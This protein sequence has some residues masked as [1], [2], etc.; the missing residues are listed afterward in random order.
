MDKQPHICAQFLASGRYIVWFN[1]FIFVVA[2][3]MSE[4]AWCKVLHLLLALILL[5]LH[6]R[7]DFDRR[8]FADFAKNR[9]KPEE[10]D[11]VLDSWGWL[12]NRQSR[13]MQQR[14]AGALK[15]WRYLLWATGIQV[16][17]IAWK[18]V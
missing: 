9:F 12:R 7:L 8:I 15:L 17:L 1:A 16:G 11:A 4:G 14:V 13:E 6:I 3:I 5:Y 2:F 10:F 18:G